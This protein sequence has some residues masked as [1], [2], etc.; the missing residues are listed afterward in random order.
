MFE[1]CYGHPDL[2]SPALAIHIVFD[3]EESRDKLGK[4]LEGRKALGA[5]QQALR[6][7]RDYPQSSLIPAILPLLE[8]DELAKD[9]ISVLARFNDSSIAETLLKKYD[10][11]S[12]VTRQATV[13]ALAGKKMFASYLLRAI[14]EKRVPRH[15]MTAYHARQIQTYKDKRLNESLA[16]VWGRAESTTGEKKKEIRYWQDQLLPDVIAKADL[17]NGYAKFQ[18]LCM[19]CHRLRGE[20][21]RLGPELDGAN[22]GDLYYLLENIIE[23]NA[24]LPADFQMTV[25]TKKDGGILSGNVNSENEYSLKLGN[26]SGEIVIQLDEIAKRETLKQSLMPEGF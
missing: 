25:V 21:G 19:A 9:A 18:T 1:S 17:K 12:V 15:A 16:K 26:L 23:P 7:L 5:P 6:I 20:G 4:L 8:D 13:D 14:E 2:R 24:T 22:R 10:G 3:E 11:F